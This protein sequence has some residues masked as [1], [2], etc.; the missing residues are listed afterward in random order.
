[1]K[2]GDRY[3]CIKD[4]IMTD[5]RITYIKNKIYTVHNK[6][7]NNYY[8]IN[9]QGSEKHSWSDDKEFYKYFQP[10]NITIPEHI[11]PIIF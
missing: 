1:M 10:E 8:I 2:I 6:I 3:I 7:G 4:V 11:I 9:E 5:K